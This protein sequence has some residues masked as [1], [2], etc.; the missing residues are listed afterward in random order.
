DLYASEEGVSAARSGYWPT[1]GAFLSG[2]LSNPEIDRITDNKNLQ[3][4]VN[5]RWNLF[6]QFRTNEG[7]Q[8]AIARKRNA[9]IALVQAERDIG[10]EVKKAMLD[11]EASSK[12]VEVSRK[13][14]VAAQ[15][16]YKIAEERYNLGAG[17]LL[18]LL[19][20]NASLVNAQVVLVNSVTT[21]IFSKFKVEYALGERTY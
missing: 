8:N 16:D 6:D 21:Y 20:A 1:L 9:E 12:S 7:I 5:F 3:W 17:T 10:V 19:V 4:G 2:S 18:D 14:L 15:E 13:G 11:L